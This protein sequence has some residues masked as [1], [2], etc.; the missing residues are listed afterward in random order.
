[1]TEAWE[2]I[3]ND[4]TSRATTD[5]AYQHGALAGVEYGYLYSELA[6]VIDLNM[7]PLITTPSHLICDLAFTCVRDG[8]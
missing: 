1:M 6:N 3:D 7:Y 2:V 5:S 8:I 4:N